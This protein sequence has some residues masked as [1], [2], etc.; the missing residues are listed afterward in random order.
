MISYDVNLFSPSIL[1]QDDAA[2]DKELCGALQIKLDR[3][4]DECDKLAAQLSSKEEARSVLHRKYQLLKQE[5]GEKVSRTSFLNV[6]HPRL[7]RLTTPTPVLSR[8][9]TFSSRL[10]SLCLVKSIKPIGAYFHKI[11]WI[12]FVNKFPDYL[13]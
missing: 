5:L 2:A 3:M 4:K 11:L 8:F 7:C 6:F 9:A 1:Y 13:F 10:L 12:Y